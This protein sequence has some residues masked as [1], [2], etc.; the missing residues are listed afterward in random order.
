MSS[1]IIHVT[2]L[3]W[4]IIVVAVDLSFVYVFVY[5]WTDKLN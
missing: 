1:T 4:T 3:V 5:D 2:W